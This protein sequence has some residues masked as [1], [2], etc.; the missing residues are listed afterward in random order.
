VQGALWEHLLLMLLLACSFKFSSLLGPACY[1]RL[2]RFCLQDCMK[3]QLTPLELLSVVLSA[4]VHDVGHPGDTYLML[5]SRPHATQPLYQIVPCPCTAAVASTWCGFKHRCAMAC[6]NPLQ[7][8][9]TQSLF[10]SWGCRL[11]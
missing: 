11:C 4:I 9:A 10:L 2:L 8:A 3:D 6:T 5:L 7:A 1:S